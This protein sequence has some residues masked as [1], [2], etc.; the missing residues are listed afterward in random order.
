[1]PPGSCRRAWVA[2][3][4]CGAARAVLGRLGEPVRAARGLCEPLVA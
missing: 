2:M 1:M 3:V 4:G